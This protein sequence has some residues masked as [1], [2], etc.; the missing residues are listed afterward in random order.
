MLV[1]LDSSTR[2]SSVL[3]LP[4]DLYYKGNKLSR[5]YPIYGAE[6]FKRIVSAITGLSVDRY[7]SID[8]F[9]FIDVIDII[10]G[11]DIYL[12]KPLID[13]TYVIKENGRFTTLHYG[14]GHHRLGGVEALR[15][16]RSR[17]TTSDFGRIARQQMILMGV[18]D[19]LASLSSGTVGSAV[20]IARTLW[21]YVKT[22]LSA[23][24]LMRQFLGH[25]DDQ[26]RMT[27]LSWDNVLYHGYS[28]TYL[29]GDEFE[30]DEEF[31]RGMW[32]LL[33]LDNDWEVVRRYVNGFIYGGIGG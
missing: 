33:P 22:D 15:V 32:I 9:A 20:D 17:H 10:G 7:V 1:H 11:I 25:K 23:V 26:F 14:R 27:T 24:E 31:D 4:R 30:P 2:S 13:P 29:L 18:K 3:S 28:N 19:Q 12:E 6:Q 5:L 8:M 21:E 16:A